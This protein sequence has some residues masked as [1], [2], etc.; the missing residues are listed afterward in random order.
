[1]AF[2]VIPTLRARVSDSHG[3]KGWIFVGICSRF[4]RRPFEEL[5]LQ[6]ARAIA[7]SSCMRN[8]KLKEI[9]ALERC[10][11]GIG[12]LADGFKSSIGVDLAFIRAD[13]TMAPDT[14]GD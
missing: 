12:M 1:V 3:T 4:G 13:I 11:S 8:N 5:C 9:N 10:T 6:E 2:F 14:S 7:A